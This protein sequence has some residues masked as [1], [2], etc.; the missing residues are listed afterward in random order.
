[1]KLPAWRHEKTV[2]DQDRGTALARFD[3][4]VTVE[5]F[6][7]NDSEKFVASRRREDQRGALDDVSEESAGDGIG[8]ENAADN[9]VRIYDDTPSDFH[10]RSARS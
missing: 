10:Q 1:M 4:D 8:Q 9:R 2:T 5:F 6:A 7:G 3:R